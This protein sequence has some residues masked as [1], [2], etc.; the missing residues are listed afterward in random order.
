M[1]KK[2]VDDNSDINDVFDFR[3]KS[4]KYE[5]KKAKLANVCSDC[6]YPMDECTCDFPFNN[7]TGN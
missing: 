4:F 6:G 5:T 3:S 1:T 2:I 7:D